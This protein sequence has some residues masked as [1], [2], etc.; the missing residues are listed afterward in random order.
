MAGFGAVG[1][2]AQNLGY[3]MATYQGNA[4]TGAIHWHCKWEQL[5]DE[6]RVT[7]A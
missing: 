4:A 5:S 3:L 7:E 2:S 1:K 6:G